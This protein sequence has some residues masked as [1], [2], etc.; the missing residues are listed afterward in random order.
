[1]LKINELDKYREDNRLE[2]KKAAGGLPKSLWETYSAFANTEHRGTVL[3]CCEFQHKRTVPLC[4]RRGL[5][6]HKQKHYTWFRCYM[7]HSPTIL[8]NWLRIPS[9]S[10]VKSSVLTLILFPLII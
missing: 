5:P 1:M 2:A 4:S 7:A 6:S 9:K 8:S 10:L 3:L